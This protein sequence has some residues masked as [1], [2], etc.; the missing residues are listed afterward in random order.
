MRCRRCIETLLR[1]LS[2]RRTKCNRP[3]K[4]SSSAAL[5][6]PLLCYRSWDKIGNYSALYWRTSLQKCYLWVL[7]PLE[8]VE[9]WLCAIIPELKLLSH[10]TGSSQDI[11]ISQWNWISC[12]FRSHNCVSY[13][14]YSQIPD[15]NL[16]C[17]KGTFWS[18]PPLAKRDWFSGLKQR[19]KTLLLWPCFCLRMPLRLWEV[20]FVS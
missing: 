1:G 5:L 4:T 3:K 20:F 19:E 11:V 15:V 6:P 14:S 12:H 13:L 18:H 8:C 17:D 10:L 2:S 9:K 16:N 7:V